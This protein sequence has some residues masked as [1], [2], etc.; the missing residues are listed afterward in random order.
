MYK[1]FCSSIMKTFG[2]INFFLVITK[3]FYQTRNF[4]I[5]SRL[6]VWLEFGVCHPTRECFTHMETSPLPIHDTHSHWAV[7]VIWRATPTVTQGVRLLWSSPR[8]HDT[9]TCCRGFSSGAVATCFNQLGLSRLGFEHPTYRLRG[10]C[11][12]P[13]RLFLVI[14]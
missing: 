8:I 2:I 1:L 14:T 9:R 5:L 12:N 7:S 4:E 13:L 3:Y 10:E 11:S 6:F